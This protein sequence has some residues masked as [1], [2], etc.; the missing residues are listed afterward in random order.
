MTGT[1]KIRAKILEDASARA[2]AIEEQAR[3]E[4]RAIMDQASDEAGRKRAELLKKAE[5]DGAESYKRLLAVAG[6]EGRKEIL[7]AKQDMIDE[8]FQSALEKVMGLSDK[9]Y[10]KLLETMIIDA[11]GSEGGEILLSEKDIKRLDKSF[12]GNINQLLAAKGKKGMVTFSKQTI[13]TAGGFILRSGELE[14]N[15][16]FEILF[17]MLR[18]ELESDV[19]GILFGEG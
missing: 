9:E 13:K 16:T 19:V 2:A 14:V 12:I 3:D 17:G 8:A 4:A 6:L 18:S 15:S 7:R 1:E 5:A 11:A 10:Q